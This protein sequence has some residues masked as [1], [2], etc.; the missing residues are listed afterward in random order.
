MSNAELTQLALTLLR[1][2]LN[3]IFSLKKLGMK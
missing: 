2:L 3:S 1:E